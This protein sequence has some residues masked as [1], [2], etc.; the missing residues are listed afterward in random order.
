[1]CCENFLLITS[2]LFYKNIVQLTSPRFISVEKPVRDE[3][4]IP[5]INPHFY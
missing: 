2:D 4:I 1:M 3:E 5:E